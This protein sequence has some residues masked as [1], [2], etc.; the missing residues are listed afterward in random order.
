MTRRGFQGFTLIELLVVIALIALLIGIL[1]PALG[2]AR[3]QARITGCGARLQQI[4]VGLQVYLNDFNN[5]PQKKGPLPTGGSSVIGSL[6]AGKKGQLP[7]YGIV[8]I[9]AKERPLNPYVGT[10]IDLSAEEEG[11]LELPQFKSPI[12]KGSEATGLPIPGLDRTDR[13][14]DFVGCSYVL[15]D[16][17][18]EG[19]EFGTLIPPGGGRLKEPAK[20]TKTW[21]VATHTIYNYQQG[22]DRGMKWFGEQDGLGGVNANML[23]F[24]GHIRM[25]VDIPVGIVN[26]TKDYT[27][28]P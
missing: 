9:G 6:F 12:D 17:T 14:Y 3:Q 13:M 11:E 27:F 8:S 16:H 23:F 26:T 10:E 21:V 4:G 7:F 24:D 5:L 15:N 22:G 18:L 25:S 28:L 1:L 19:E 2:S 20:P